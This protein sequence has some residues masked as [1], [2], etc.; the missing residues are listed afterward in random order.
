[1]KIASWNV[2]SIRARLERALQFLARHSPDVACF[3]ETKVEDEHFPREPFL[4]QGWHLEVYG[5]KTYNGVAIL[6]REPLRDVQRGLGD[7]SVDPEAR[8]IAGTYRDV[9]VMNVYVPNGQEPSS[10]KFQY[11][12]EWLE[13]LRA[14]LARRALHQ[15]PLL[16]GGD[17]NIAPEDRD[18]YDPDGWRGQVLFHPREHEA[19]RRIQE[20]GL[21]DAFRMHHSEG[22][23]YTWWDFRGA[24]FWKNK[25]L[26]ID[27]LLVTARLAERCLAADIDV[28][29][30]KF[31]Q[32]SDHAPVLATFRD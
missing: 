6:S 16:L 3:Q 25:G 14:V 8:M 5:Q 23:H 28:R 1:M 31:K 32:P 19:L 20:L 30:R 2:N 24:M 15:E 21:R 9:R 22:G 7:G 12:L 18:V 11:K 29:E 10:E 4:A 26:R 17:F 13:R 27:H